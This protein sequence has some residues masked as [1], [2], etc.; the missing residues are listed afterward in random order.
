VLLG[1][2]HQP[3]DQLAVPASAPSIPLGPSCCAVVVVSMGSAS[4]WNYPAIH[5]RV[6]TR[7][8]PALRVIRLPSIPL[9]C[10]EKR[11]RPP[12]A[13][14]QQRRRG[15]GCNVEFVQTGRKLGSAFE[16]NQPGSRNIANGNETDSGR[17]RRRH[18]AAA[19]L[20]QERLAPGS[21]PF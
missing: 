13:T 1:G 5:R 8:S 12:P 17:R 14:R 20:L 10:S 16:A 18:C 4:S 9:K 21:V 7:R 15:F 19:A 2:G 11:K 3:A 6:S